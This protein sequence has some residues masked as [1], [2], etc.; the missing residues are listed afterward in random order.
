MPNEDA[1]TYL[2]AN[3]VPTA[4][5]AF[6]R[7]G[8]IITPLFRFNRIPMYIAKLPLTLAAKIVFAE[9]ATSSFGHPTRFEYFK[10][11]SS[12]SRRT[13]LTRSTVYRAV[14]ELKEANLIWVSAHVSASSKNGRQFYEMAWNGDEATL[15]RNHGLKATGAKTLTY[16]I[17]RHC[18]YVPYFF[19]L[20]EGSE[21]KSSGYN[22]LLRVYLKKFSPRTILVDLIMLGY[23]YSKAYPV[24]FRSYTKIAADLCTKRQ[25]I[26]ASLHRL[27]KYYLIAYADGWYPVAHPVMAAR[28]I[29]EEFFAVVERVQEENDV[30]S[31]VPEEVV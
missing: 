16:A 8:A 6:N 9:I 27:E 3:Q 28:P 17:F 23:V 26:A 18:L 11:F 22:S 12:M 15:E 29:K 14:K 20:G 2:E 21:A 5:S 10:G 13:G 25:T 7:I 1:I 4:E 30:E 19:S 24:C 31:E